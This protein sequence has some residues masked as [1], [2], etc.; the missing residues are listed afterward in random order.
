MRIRPRDAEIRH[1]RGELLYRLDRFE[2]SARELAEAV[3]LAPES[4]AAHEAAFD[5]GVALTRLER[6][7]EAADAYELFLDESP[8]PT[9]RAIALTNLAETRM[10][11]GRLEEA[12]AHYR[13][14]IATQP[15]YTHGYLGMAVALDR[16]GDEAAAREAM[17]TALSTGAGLEELDNPAV[18]FVP[19]WEHHYYR[20]LALDVSGRVVEAA[21]E[22]Q[23]FL[24]EGGG[25]G[26][27]AARVREHL[28][29]LRG[30]TDRSRR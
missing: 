26:P 21:A 14:A 28:E 24:D 5:L 18:F 6:F 7:D 2:E 10:G 11:Q 27:Y 17:L 8:W 12:M 30:A 29:G 19:D 1:V 23:A 4:A 16:M 20:A 22:W 9:A 15:R 3:R 13:T 25:S